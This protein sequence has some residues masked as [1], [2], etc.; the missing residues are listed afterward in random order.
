MVGFAL[1]Q[2]QGEMPMLNDP[3]WNDYRKGVIAEAN[4]RGPMPPSPA[5]PQPYMGG[6]PL[7]LRDE[8]QIASSGPRPPRDPERHARSRQDYPWLYER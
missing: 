3:A 2:P 8:Y 7:D 5:I 6:I 4:A 1:R